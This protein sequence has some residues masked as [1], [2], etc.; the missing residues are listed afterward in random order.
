[1]VLNLTVRD[2]IDT[3][4]SINGNTLTANQTGANYQWIACNN[5]NIAIPGATNTSYTVTNVGSY[6]VAITLETCID[7]STC[8]TINNVGIM[9][10]NFEQQLLVYPNPTAGN[11]TID[12]GKNYPNLT[13]KITDLAGKIVHSKVHIESQLLQLKIEE[14]A[15]IYLLLIASGNQ[16]AIIRLVK[17]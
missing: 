12:L 5:G 10:N 16:K 15:C 13:I 2:T 8:F 6:A 1:V 7:T 3:S 14:P 17:E 4:L 9:E 11:L